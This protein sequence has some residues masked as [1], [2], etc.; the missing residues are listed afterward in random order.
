MT[1]RI[2]QGAHDLA[3]PGRRV[4]TSQT[5]P[6]PG[7]WEIVDHQGCDRHGHL[8]AFPRGEIAPACPRCGQEVVW[9]LTH[10]APSV[11]A[12]HRDVGPLP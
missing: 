4:A 8:Q 12:D 6:G 5:V 10:L 2:E 9:Q 1:D 11:A 7:T 3:W